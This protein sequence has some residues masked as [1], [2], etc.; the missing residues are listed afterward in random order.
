MKLWLAAV[1]TSSQAKNQAR[2]QVGLADDNKVFQMKIKSYNAVNR[3]KVI[4]IEPFLSSC[5]QDG[6]LSE[7]EIVNHMEVF[8]GGGEGLRTG[9][10]A[11]DEL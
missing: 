8:T 2:R 7:M 4:D 11:K 5:I 10:A 6:V 9:Q 1:N 3:L